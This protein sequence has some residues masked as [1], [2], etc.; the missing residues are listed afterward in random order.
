ML[1][2]IEIDKIEIG[3]QAATAVAVVVA[4]ATIIRHMGKALLIQIW[5]TDVDASF[6]KQ[7]WQLCM[8]PNEHRF[9][10]ALLSLVCCTRVRT[11]QWMCVGVW[12]C[13]RLCEF[14]I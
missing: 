12:L 10:M 11:E 1:Q 14:V 3:A 5:T 2:E 13:V 7:P 8:K 6:A 4:I 9:N